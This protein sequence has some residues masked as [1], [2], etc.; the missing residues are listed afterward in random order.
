MCD[1]WRFDWYVDREFLWTLDLEMMNT[2]S[3]MMNLLR[4]YSQ[5]SFDPPCL[6]SACDLCLCSHEPIARCHAIK[7]N[8]AFHKIGAPFKNRACSILITSIHIFL[9]FALFSIRLPYYML[10]SMHFFIFFHI[11]KMITQE[12]IIQ[13]AW[14]FFWIVHHV[15]YFFM[16]IFSRFVHG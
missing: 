11:K 7:W 6:H 8:G 13:I 9:F 12:I 3:F 15:V 14:L 16:D 5:K 1:A 4:F 10:P 2:M